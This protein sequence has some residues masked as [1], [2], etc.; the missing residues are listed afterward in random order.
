MTPDQ[1]AELIADIEKKLA[2]AEYLTD[3]IDKNLAKYA[4]KA[5]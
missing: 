1:I 3:K 2:R 5:A 4:K